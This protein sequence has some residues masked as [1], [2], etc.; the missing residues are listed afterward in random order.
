VQTIV[1]AAIV[2][3]RSVVGFLRFRPM[4]FR[5]LLPAVLACSLTPAAQPGDKGATRP[6][7]LPP[8]FAPQP[9]TNPRPAPR[10]RLPAASTP[11]RR[12]ISPELAKKLAETVERSVAES[13]L[14]TASA[15]PPK[16]NPSDSSE[17]TVLEPFV[18]QDDKMS[19]LRPRDLLTPEAR[20]ELAYRLN[21]GLRGLGNKRVAAEMAEEELAKVRREEL[22][23]LNSVLTFEGA[24]APPGVQRQIDNAML[25]KN[26][27][28]SSP[29]GTR[30]REIR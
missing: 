24:K 11:S 1:S 28:L 15:A 16:T 4:R 13:K 29:P 26:D 30:F 20:L 9:A 22:A 10:P 6:E 2:G 5:L 18:V 25:R 17:P 8:I 23:E 3:T 12:A 19:R 27:W 14:A 7:A 21:P